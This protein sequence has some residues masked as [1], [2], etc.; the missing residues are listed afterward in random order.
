MGVK[1]QHEQVAAAL[2]PVPRHRIDRPHRQRVIAAEED[3]QR[4]GGCDLI[5]FATQRAR[6]ALD[7]A[8]MIGVLRWPVGEIPHL[9]G[10]QVAVVDDLEV[11]AFE[12]C[13]QARGAQRRRAHQGAA[14]RGPHVDGRA[15]QGDAPGSI[16]HNPV[17]HGCL[18][19]SARPP[20]PNRDSHPSF[21]GELAATTYRPEQNP[22]RR[23][24]FQGRP[25][26]STTAPIVDSQRCRLQSSRLEVA[27][28]ST[29]I[30]QSTSQPGIAERAID[31]AAD[32]S[33]TIGEV[34]GGVHA[35]VDRL[36]SAVEESRKP[37]GALATVAAITREAPLASLFVAF[38]F[39]VAVARRR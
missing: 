36:T 6:P 37:G 20:Q 19:T 22:V 34:A 23:I 38:L 15:E 7:F 25:P 27:S 29:E 24:A 32:V 13:C 2:L 3:R 18:L 1:P 21:P 31:T 26:P 11:E 17:G 35:A 39:G 5:A 10:G 12:Q 4:A 14:L 8:V 30:P 28:L 33:R 16:R 9:G